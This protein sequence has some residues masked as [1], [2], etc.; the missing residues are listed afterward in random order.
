MNES[1]SNES[2]ETEQDSASAEDPG[3]KQFDASLRTTF[4][5]HRR[6][7][8]LTY[9]LFVI[10]NLLRLAQPFALGW[11]INDLIE[12]RWLGLYVLI[13]QHVLHLLFGLWRQVLDTRVFTTVYSDIVTNMIV[14]QRAEG[15][16]VSRVAARSTLSREYVGFFELT[17]P[18][19][20]RA[21]F[22]IVGSLVMLAL[23]DWL[24]VVVSIG[25]LAPAAF[26]NRW[27]IKR[28]RR[29]NLN[30]HNELEREVDFIEPGQE[31]ELKE[32]FKRLAGWRIRLS[33]A[34]AQN[35]GM[36]EVAVLGVIVFT[37]I[38]TTGLG[39]TTGD[40]F[41]VFRYLMVLLMGLDR[42]PQLIMQVSR[43]RDIQTRMK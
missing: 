32:H 43:V 9:S 10:E 8:S 3:A 11:A 16:D 34:E 27:F 38:R 21:G 20:F 7:I 5:S 36:M 13:G 23:Y 24:V 35:F 42:I 12:E 2:D 33:N 31:A 1:L 26:I 39:V 15:V 37:L 30:L 19:V 6:R 4:R 28:I 18:N 25:L 40:V 17:L 22:S 14:K 41:A 29:L